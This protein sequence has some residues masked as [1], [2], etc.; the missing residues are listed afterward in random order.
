MSQPSPAT[1]TGLT[2]QQ[3]PVEPLDAHGCTASIVGTVVFGLAAAACWLL[4]FR[5]IWVTILAT[6]SGCGVIL[7]PY[8][9]WRRAVHH[10]RTSKSVESVED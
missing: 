2:L 6:C 3:A 10:R 8:T 5:G 4:D 1:H 7:I 9:I